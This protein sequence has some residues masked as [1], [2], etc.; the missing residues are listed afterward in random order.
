MRASLHIRPDE[1]VESLE[2]A[3]CHKK[4]EN[5]QVFAGTTRSVAHWTLLFTLDVYFA[6]T[7]NI[8]VGTFIGLKSFGMQNNAFVS[9]SVLRLATTTIPL[10]QHVGVFYLSSV[11]E[12]ERIFL[13][14]IFSDVL[15]A[16]VHPE[17]AISVVFHAMLVY[18]KHSIFR[19]L[20][21]K[22]DKYFFVGQFYDF[23]FL[24]NFLCKFFKYFLPSNNFN[25]LYITSMYTNLLQKENLNFKLLNKYIRYVSITLIILKKSF[26]FNFHVLD[27]TLNYTQK[28]SFYIR[29]LDQNS[30]A[31]FLSFNK[32]YFIQL[33]IYSA[34]H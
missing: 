19:I 30:Q 34:V 29:S 23:I 22:V 32:L 7:K 9:W 24:N 31:Q 15:A 6:Q 11:G 20:T 8:I 25:S 17:V 33:Y 2:D 26:F 13:R 4:C 16:Y 5:R 10:Y 3:S 12:D 27:N 28:V 21:V 14:G 1:R 18:R